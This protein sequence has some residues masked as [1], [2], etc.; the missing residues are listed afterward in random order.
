MAHSKN[1]LHRRPL[2]GAKFWLFLKKKLNFVFNFSFLMILFWVPLVNQIMCDIV[3]ALL[4]VGRV[5][6][7][8]SG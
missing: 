7:K 6:K 5:S 1:E 4:V 3:G 2:L 8:K